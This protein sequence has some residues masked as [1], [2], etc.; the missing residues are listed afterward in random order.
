MVVTHTGVTAAQ[1]RSAVG[2]DFDAAQATQQTAFLE[3]LAERV[4]VDPGGERWKA[5]VP[6]VFKERWVQDG[7]LASMDD[8]KYDTVMLQRNPWAR[9]FESFCEQPHYKKSI[10]D[11]LERSG[12]ALSRENAQLLTSCDIHGSVLAAAAREARS[13]YAGLTHAYYNLLVRLADGAAPAPDCYKHLQAT[14]SGQKSTGLQNT[15]PGWEELIR[16]AIAAVPAEGRG[17]PRGLHCMTAAGG[18][19]VSPVQPKNLAP[20]GYRQTNSQRGG[21]M[22]VQDSVVVKFVSAGRD[23]A[24]LHTAVF[25]DP[26]SCAFPPMTLFTAVDVHIGAFEFDSTEGLLRECKRRYGGRAPT[27]PPGADG[28]PRVG[29]AQLLEWLVE[30][31]NEGWNLSSSHP[32]YQAGIDWFHVSMLPPGVE[33]TIYTVHRTLVTVHATYLLPTA[34]AAVTTAR[35]AAG[36]AMAAVAGGGTFAPAPTAAAAAG[37]G[38]GS[39]NVSD[40]VHAKLMADSTQLG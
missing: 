4:G 36:A 28:R 20:E 17:R 30:N 39:G 22:E 21:A 8:P 19:I 27:A 37:G 12:G 2:R 18:T 33:S 26:I 13:D 14:T 7:K 3:A 1:L 38:G 5:E 31:T 23:S 29:R 6:T 9:S 40:A 15:E 25:T 10:D 11:Q 16:T 32:S 35:V 34:T 24:G